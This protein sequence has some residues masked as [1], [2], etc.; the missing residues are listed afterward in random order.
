[1]TDSNTV[2]CAVDNIETNIVLTTPKEDRKKVLISDQLQ[3]LHVNEASIFFHVNLHIQQVK[4]I[5]WITQTHSTLAVGVLIQ[6][7]ST[8]TANCAHIAVLA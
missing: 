5:A 1:M 8:A 3:T 4:Y 7:L 6:F 2:V